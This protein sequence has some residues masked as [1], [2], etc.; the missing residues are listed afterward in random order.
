M[1]L[2]ALNWYLLVPFSYESVIRNRRSIQGSL[3]LRERTSIYL[4]GL[5]FSFWHLPI[6]ES[7]PGRF[8]VIG[9]PDGT[10]LLF[11]SDYLL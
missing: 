1:G 4:R 2:E 11:I 10:R 5:S 3:K 6:N 9:S 7:F 8:L